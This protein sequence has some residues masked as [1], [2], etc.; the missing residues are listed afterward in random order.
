SMAAASL[1]ALSA[2]LASFAATASR[3]FRMAVFSLEL[4]ALFSSARR[5]FCRIRFWDERDRATHELL[6]CSSNAIHRGP[7]DSH[8]CIRRQA[9]DGRFIERPAIRLSFRLADK[10]LQSL[11]G[12]A[13]VVI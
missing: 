11:S 3:T 13:I 7:P 9:A 2:A 12:V 8:G 4:R 5:L 1:K 10:F 6:G